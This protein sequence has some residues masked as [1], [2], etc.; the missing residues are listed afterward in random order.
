MLISHSTGDP[1]HE[2]AP[3]FRSCFALVA[4]FC[5]QASKKRCAVHIALDSTVRLN[6]WDDLNRRRLGLSVLTCLLCTASSSCC[7]HCQAGN[8]CLSHQTQAT[9]TDPH[10]LK[11]RYLSISSPHYNSSRS[12]SH[13]KDRKS[14][15]KGQAERTRKDKKRNIL[16]IPCFKHLVHNKQS[17]LNFRPRA[18]QFGCWWPSWRMW[19]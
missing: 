6:F 8:A 11:L 19:G 7:R 13:R 9:V 14:I 16:S 10:R 15:K 2:G 5:F 1:R 18:Q 12:H 4:T 17:L 3:L